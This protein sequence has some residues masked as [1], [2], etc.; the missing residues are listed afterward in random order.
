MSACEAK[1]EVDPP[2]SHL[3]AF[4]TSIAV[5]LVILCALQMITSVGHSI[6]HIDGDDTLLPSLQSERIDTGHVRADDESVNVVGPF[7]GLH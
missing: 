6:P 3:Q 7:V 5:R 4:L 2:V 1:P